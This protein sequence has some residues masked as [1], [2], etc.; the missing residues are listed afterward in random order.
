M[1][2]MLQMLQN[3]QTFANFQKLELQNL[4]DLRKCWKTR[5]YTPPLGGQKTQ[6][7]CLAPQKN[8]LSVVLGSHFQSRC[9]VPR[10]DD[11]MMGW[12]DVVMRG[13]CDDDII[14]WWRPIL[15]HFWAIFHGFQ[16]KNIRKWKGNIRNGILADAWQPNRKGWRKYH[17]SLPIYFFFLKIFGAQGTAPSSLDSFTQLV[18]NSSNFYARFRKRFRPSIWPC[19][20]FS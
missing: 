8:L 14:G 7:Y 20:V 11:A 17:S 12:C 10:C 5:I 9:G 15:G 6:A 13:W 19:L 4:V 16:K 18:I 2:Q 3:L 1:L